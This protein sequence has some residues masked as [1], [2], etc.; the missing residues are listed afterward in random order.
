MY[1]KVKANDRIEHK[2]TR[3]VVWLSS[4]KEADQSIFEPYLELSK[5]NSGY[6]F[7]RKRRKPIFLEELEMLES[8]MIKQGV[9]VKGPTIP[10]VSE[11]VK[12]EIK[13]YKN[14]EKSSGLQTDSFQ[15]EID[16]E[17]FILKTA[18]ELLYSLENNT[19]NNPRSYIL[20][21][22][23]YFER[24]S[25]FLNEFDKLDSSNHKELSLILRILK[26][27][28]R[29]KLKDKL[30]YSMCITLPITPIEFKKK[31]KQVKGFQNTY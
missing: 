27:P 21:C 25:K 24:F 23:G 5:L 6:L 7:R 19:F 30:T 31:L 26:S 14:R 9:V 10:R 28:T 2:L 15:Y 22:I 11:L 3:K 16:L 29:P 1:K 12:K 4:L 20:S 13:K 8:E 17:K 18:E